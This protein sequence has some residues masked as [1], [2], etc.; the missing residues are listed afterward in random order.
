MS[1]S[2]DLTGRWVGH[3]VQNDQEHP[4]TA[5]LVQLADRLSG[6]MYDGRPDRECSVFEAACQAGLPP[7]TDEQIAANLRQMVPAVPG[8]PIRY[9]A[10]VPT[11]S[12]L[13]GRRSGRTVSFLKTYQGISFDGYKVGDQLVG[14]QKDAHAVHYEG[15]LSPDGLV[16]EGRWWIDADPAYATR[17]TESTFLLRRWE[18]HEAFSEE[19]T[20]A[21]EQAKRSSLESLS[22]ESPCPQCGI[23]TRQ[24]RSD[25]RCVAC[26]KPLPAELSALTSLPDEAAYRDSLAELIDRAKSLGCDTFKLINDGRMRQLVMELDKLGGANLMR[27]ALARVQATSG[28]AQ[29]DAVGA[30]WNII[31]QFRQGNCGMCGKALPE[32]EV[33][34]VVHAETGR[35]KP[36]CHSCMLQLTAGLAEALPAARTPAEAGRPSKKPWWATRWGMG[37]FNWL[38]RRRQK[39]EP[40]PPVASQHYKLVVEPKTVANVES[41]M[42]EGEE[43]PIGSVRGHAVA[44]FKVDDVRRGYFLNGNRVSLEEVKRE[45]VRLAQIGGVVFYYRENPDEEAPR[46]SEAVN[47]AMAIIAAIGAARLPVTFV[48]RDYD[49]EVKVAEYLLPRGA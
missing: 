11:N 15:Q 45:C 30:A 9:V 41:L 31:M 2:L 22:I 4:I 42:R 29:A 39:A 20:A 7:G 5:D 28:R 24:S 33:F 18:G 46:E 38:F 34:D 6:S 14:I 47:R 25:G 3:Y 1:L 27:L 26:G 10:H 40:K 44:H 43:L 13:E 16:I 32:G 36:V 8:A 49:P 48:S 21:S 37:F 35:Q 12:V 19:Q 23:V 17:R